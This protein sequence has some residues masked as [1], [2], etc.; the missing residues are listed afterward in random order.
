[1]SKACNIHITNVNINLQLMGK[2]SPRLINLHAIEHLTYTP[3]DSVNNHNV[4]I[5]NSFVLD[6]LNRYNMSTQKRIS[7]EN[8]GTIP[9]VT[10]YI[11]SIDEDN[12]I[13]KDL[14]PNTMKV[15]KFYLFQTKG[16]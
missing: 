8:K 16:N 11:T 5:I 1:M 7:Y 13:D 9:N 3:Y 10:T 14:Y 2:D 12:N 4:E 15:I 6:E